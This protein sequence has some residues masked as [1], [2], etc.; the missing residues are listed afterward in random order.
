MPDLIRP[1]SPEYDSA[2]LAWN[3]AADQH[4]AAIVVAKSV[5]EVVDAVNWARENGLRIAA[6]TTGHGAPGLPDL[7]QCLL[8]KTA[9][10]DG[11][12]DIDT[13]TATAR[14]PAGAPIG[15]V[16]AAAA[17]RGL[18]L[19]HGSS[20]TVGVVGYLLGGGLSSYARTYGLACNRVSSFQAVTE[21]GEVVTADAVSNPDLFWA[22][23]GGGGGMAVVTS[24]EIELLPMS[25]V[26]A[27]ASFF[28]ASVAP[29][30][31]DAWINWT[32]NAPDT[33]TTDL[34]IMRL[35]PFEEIPEPIRGQTVV[36]IDGVITDPAV[37]EEF[38]ALLGSVAQAVM[39]G[40][41]MMPVADIVRLH[42]DPEDPVPGAG[43]S[44]LLGSLDENAARAFLDA[45]GEDSP[46][47]LMIAELRHI[48]GALARPAEDGGALD[49][50][51][52]EYLLSAIGMAAGPDMAAK[53][54]AD[55]DQVTASMG[56]WANGSKLFNFCEKNFELSDC[57]TPASVERLNTVLDQY[58]PERVFV[59]PGSTA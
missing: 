9:L 42:G 30:V 13:N 56:P 37:G 48:G 45:V 53:A 36:C 3:L 23:R 25:E 35:P 49:R 1:E 52:G 4:P 8:L 33:A 16:V 31:L 57:L 47:S 55:L 27:G 50:I 38:A 34:R 6:Q 14:V 44:L 15:D 54:V 40:W 17:E 18:A 39:G 11:E 12:L 2:R 21:N 24:I 41:G 51:E 10:Y 43:D 29:Q 32:R 20:P 28:P 5:D 22:L 58:S 19:L 59:S 46:S 26:F 7:S